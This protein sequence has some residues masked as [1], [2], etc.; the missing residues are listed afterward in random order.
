MNVGN[1]F[2][3]RKQEE[4]RESGGQSNVVYMILEDYK[5][6]KKHP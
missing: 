1:G 2:V 5:I 4:G 6:N 3:G